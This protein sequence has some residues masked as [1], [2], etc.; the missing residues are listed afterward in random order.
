MIEPTTTEPSRA[1][2]TTAAVARGLLWLFLAAWLVFFAVWGALHG[3]IVPRIAD[4]RPRIEAEASRVL[5]VQVHIGSISARSDGLVPSFSLSDVVLLD[6]QGRT[7]L[8]LPRVV[9]ALSPRSLFKRG[10]EQLYLDAPELDVRRAADGRIFVAGMAV[11]DQPQGGGGADWLFSQ[12]EVV[13]RQGTLRWTDEQRGAPPLALAQV[14]LLLRN[15]TWRHDLRL[16]ATPPA[17]WGSRF[18]VTGRFRQPL[19]AVHS[20]RWQ[21]WGGEVQGDFP[22][23]DVA[24]LLAHADPALL[25]LASA[26]GQGAVR[27][28]ADVD[29]GRITGGTLDL[30]LRDIAAHFTAAPAPL[31]LRELQG[32]FTGHRSNAGFDV[33]SR[34][35][36]FETSDGLRWPGGNAELRY[37]EATRTQAALGAL[38]ADH[39]DLGAL[40]Q[41]AESLPLGDAVHRQWTRHAPRGQVERLEAQWEG[42][43]AAPTRYLA[44]GHVSDLAW[45]S[46]PPEAAALAAAAAA[47]A[48]L[49]RSDPSGHHHAHPPLGTPGVRGATVEFDLNQTGGTAQVA[50]DNGALDFPGVFEEPVVPMDTLRGEVRWQRGGDGRLSLQ[51][52]RMVFANADTAGEVQATWHTG[53]GDMRLPGILDLSGSLSRADGTRVHRYLPQ[54]IPPEARHY[55]RDAITAGVATS[56]QFHVRGDLR[57]VPASDAKQGEFHI[58]AKLRDVA[59]NY[60]PPSTQP[61]GRPPWPALANLS[62][63]LVFDRNS[64][65]VR[66]AAGRLV[67]PSGKA[68]EVV[69]T[70]AEARIPDLAR[71]VVGVQADAQGPLAEMLG[72]VN[73]SP[74]AAMTADALAHA[75]AT[76]MAGLRLGLELPI[77]NIRDSKVKG[78]LA[79]AGNDLRITPDTPLLGRIRGNVA[80]TEGG[81]AVAGAQMRLLGGDAKVDGNLRSTGAPAPGATGAAGA[82][83]PGASPEYVLA[84]RAQGT[85]T[86]DG[87]RQARELGA[88]ARIGDHASG[89]APYTAALTIRGGGHPELSIN[90][91]LQGLAL[92]FPAPLGKAA[93]AA[94]PLR[95]ENTVQRESGGAGPREQIAL[96][97]GSSLQVRYVRDLSGAVPRVLRG[98][99]AVGL[100]AGESAPLPDA[101]V[102]AN[103]RVAQLD[104][105]AWEAALVGPAPGRAEA[106]A[107]TVPTASSASALGMAATAA[108]DYLP[109]TLALR[110]GV[111]TADGR[112]LR[113]LVV[114]GSRSGTVWRGNLDADELSGYLEY[115]EAA[116]AAPPR[117][118]ARLARLRVPESAT[119]EVEN[120]L[121]EKAPAAAEAS[122]SQLPA[123]DIVVDDFE[124]KNRHLG[125]LEVDAVNRPDADGR[126]REWRLNKLSLS[127]PEATFA[128]TGRWARLARG[129]AARHT[130]MDFR[131][132]IRDA[133]ALLGRF[134][135]AGVVQRGAGRLQGQV[136]W[137]GSPFT[138]DYGSMDGTLH[139]DVASGQ[140]LKA[141]PGLAKLLGVLSLQS[142]PR[143]LA[144]DFRDVFSEGFAFDFVR[145][146]VRIDN[147]TAR[148]NN[149][150]MKG[151]NAAV[152]MDGSADIQHETQDIRVVVV[153]EINAG[154]ASL[155]A[156]VINPAVGL[157][158][159]LAQVFLRGPLTQAATQE[160]HVTGGWSDPKIVKLTGR[161]RLGAQP[162]ASASTP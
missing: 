13:V 66:N 152:L 151:V 4:F 3:W 8:R 100:G 11:G 9:A 125:K 29:R 136:D 154:T 55:V 126:D 38:K 56:A 72:I 14:D 94:L 157:G 93:E 115:R 130:D 7:A 5:G 61:A 116:G 92:D 27:A 86:A 33:S 88:V 110:V 95:Y 87:L 133:G 139:L 74:L 150:Q 1:L 20:G 34:G 103:V 91:S 16:D 24:Q 145:G 35:L 158:T 156:A 105:D 60:A 123:L 137:K 75:T 62:G 52:P 124:L 36:D 132:D 44:R 51:V 57:H 46:V 82:A 90:S 40:A 162:P 6:A 149:L 18:T 43:V 31:A 101:G 138:P 104:A 64:M 76:G 120:L 98:S 153:P 77:A 70:R 25:G 10:F 12:A 17:D 54:G 128:A 21:D 143:R 142:L 129:D 41:L 144:L 108:Q 109:D 85:A 140:F 30:A 65:E 81:L 96:D 131:L 113:N 114:G 80:F 15:R 89:A 68:G 19:L 22:H 73:G 78:T 59:Y 107:R 135:M 84:F 155:V 45:A 67:G 49:L 48:A 117:V 26:S 47:E 147:G 160:F 134:G 106:A 83:V 23:V 79:L 53:E 119:T 121:G 159:F 71:S 58:T 32:R 111:L 50:I 146:D 37:T 118:Y 97:L 39:L 99:I 122:G 42:D 112:T 161:D 102:S 63:E 127:L 141:D 2:K 148:T 69:V 28:W